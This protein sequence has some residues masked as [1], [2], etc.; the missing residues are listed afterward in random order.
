MLAGQ[1]QLHEGPERNPSFLFSGDGRIGRQNHA[2]TEDDFDDFVWPAPE[3][4]RR[5]EK[6]GAALDALTAL[7]SRRARVVRREER[8]Q[9]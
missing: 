3:P 8:R 6:I 2:S 4:L 9:V 5:P 7:H 1:R